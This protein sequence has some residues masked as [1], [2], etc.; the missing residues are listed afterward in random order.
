MEV[1]AARAEVQQDLL[2]YRLAFEE[3]VKRVQAQAAIPSEGGEV[4]VDG[5]ELVGV[6]AEAIIKALTLNTWK[7]E[8]ETVFQGVSVPSLVSP[9]NVYIHLIVV[10]LLRP[11][12]GA[13][14][15]V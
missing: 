15:G 9:C 13:H 4:E 2:K 5:T 6:S 12:V 14:R 11:L 1:A 8:D 3:L 10:H 7:A